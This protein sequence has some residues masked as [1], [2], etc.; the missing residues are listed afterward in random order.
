M[1]DK[2][3]TSRL[4]SLLESARLLQSSLELDTI[5]KH[6]LRTVMGRLL[7]RRGL[8]AVSRPVTRKIYFGKKVLAY[9]KY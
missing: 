8:I 7:A 3:D 6:L 2:L 5:L 1:S 4:E 9:E